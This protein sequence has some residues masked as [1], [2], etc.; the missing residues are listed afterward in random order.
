MIYKR[1]VALIL[2]SLSVRSHMQQVLPPT[3]HFTYWL[4]ASVIFSRDAMN[5]ISLRLHHIRVGI[6]FVKS[7]NPCDVKNVQVHGE[8]K[9]R[10]SNMMNGTSLPYLPHEKAFTVVRNY[11]RL[12]VTRRVT[13]AAQ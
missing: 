2:K 8:R 13:L 3:E 7:D 11:S 5:S 12:H 10:K 9:Q 1:V 4:L 6:R